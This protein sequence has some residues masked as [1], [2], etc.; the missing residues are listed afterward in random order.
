VVAPDPQVARLLARWAAAP[1]PPI[2]QLTADKVRADDLAVLELQGP[3]A[4]LHAVE[5]IEIP[6]SDGLDVRIYRPSADP[7]P[8]ILY[9]HGGG[10]VIGIDGYDRPLRELARTTG[11]VIAAPNVRLAPE[12]PYPAA[13]EDALMAARWLVDAATDLSGRAGSLTIAG[14]SSGGNLA[15]VVT[16][17]LS[18]EG[19]PIASQFL[20]YPMLDATA[21]SPSYSEFATGYG[22]TREKSLW[23]FQQYLSDSVDRHDPHVSPLFERDLTGLPST[24]VIT[25][26]CDPLRD[27][28]E[29]YARAIRAAGESAVSL[30]S[31]WMIHGFFQMGAAIDAA[32]QLLL[33]IAEWLGARGRP[34]SWR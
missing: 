28:G 34:T 31:P 23:Y 4:A 7:L 30:R 12:H 27:E 16:R 14:D 29:R 21:S 8:M 24:L 26:E 20:I 11:R 3:S 6:G 2:E 19:L 9:F 25:A 13:V 32:R 1:A 18:R 10:F 5:Q 33:D 22:F 15:A 17:E